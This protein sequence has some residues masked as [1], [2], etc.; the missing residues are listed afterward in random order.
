MKKIVSCLSVLLFLSASASPAPKARDLK[1][2]ADTLGLRLERRTGVKQDLRINRVLKRG[3][4]LDLY[5]NSELAFYP[6][7]EGD[8]EWFLSQLKE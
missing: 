7:Y 2:L 4:T 5:F 8:K 1:P 6:W 3:N